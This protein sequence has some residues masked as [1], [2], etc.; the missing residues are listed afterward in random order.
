MHTAG[1]WSGD[2]AADYYGWSRAS[3]RLLKT[4]S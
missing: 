3:D 4:V 2:R 1:G